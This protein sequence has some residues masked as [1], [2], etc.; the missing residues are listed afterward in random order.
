MLFLAVDAQAAPV[1]VDDFENPT[2]MAFG[3][4]H[5]VTPD[6]NPFAPPAAPSN[7]A[8]GMRTF[9][10]EWVSAGADIPLLNSAGIGEGTVLINTAGSP[11]VEVTF[12][13]PSLAINDLTD[14][15]LND[16]FLIPFVF[17]EGGTLGTTSIEITAKTSGGDVGVYTD[18]IFES[19]GS[20]LDYF[21][22]FDEFVGIDPSDFSDIDMLTIIINK[23][24]LSGNLDMQ[25]DDPIVTTRVASAPEPASIVLVFMGLGAG[26]TLRRR[27][28]LR[29]C[30][31]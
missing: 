6:P 23:D 28:R 30:P 25:I 12:S 19:P 15:G 16:M 2:P 3:F 7:G 11:A 26:L 10:V 13:Y 4:G 29:P 21:A 24:G 18:D 27:R 14:G 9:V 1:I 22:P 8:G 5:P 17:I 31:I 20:P